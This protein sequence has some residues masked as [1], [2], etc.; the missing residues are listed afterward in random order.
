MVMNM[1]IP[2]MYDIKM[3]SYIIVT[4]YHT[5]D[6]IVITDGSVHHAALT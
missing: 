6:T 4:I 1:E 5:A 3:K 2:N